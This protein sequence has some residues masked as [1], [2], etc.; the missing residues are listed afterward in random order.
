MISLHCKGSF[1]VI[2]I[3]KIKNQ[4][5]PKKTVTFVDFEGT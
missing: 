3:N 1:A 5:I 2:R 4:I